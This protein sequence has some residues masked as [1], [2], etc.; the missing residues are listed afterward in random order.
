V[1]TDDWAVDQAA[2][3]L[4]AAGIEVSTCHERGAAPFPCR[5]FAPGGCCP[6]DDGVSVVAL[7]R[8]RVGGDVLGGELGAVCGLRAGL[9]LVVGGL[10]GVTPFDGLG[11]VVTDGDLAGTCRAAAAT[12]DLR[13]EESRTG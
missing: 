10:A 3:G 11:T 8:A 2:A 9:P 7:V 6:V 5:R 1:G 4:K 13:H 12:I